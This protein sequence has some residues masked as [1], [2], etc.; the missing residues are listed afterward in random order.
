M[1]TN[2]AKYAVP[3]G[4]R[5][6]ANRTRPYVPSLS[7]RTARRTDPTVGASTWASGSQMCSGNSGIF[8]AKAIKNVIQRKYW[9]S[10]VSSLCR[11]SQ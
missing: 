4:K 11:S 8:A 9:S 7:L 6:T 5:T 2:G 1:D 3:C 10:T